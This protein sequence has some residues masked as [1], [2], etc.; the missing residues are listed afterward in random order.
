MI[1]FDFYLK[2]NCGSFVKFLYSKQLLQLR[3]LVF[4]QATLWFYRQ[5][6]L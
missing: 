4:H 6:G 5:H 2:R 3:L 1:E